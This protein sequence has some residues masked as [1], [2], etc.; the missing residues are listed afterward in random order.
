MSRVFVD[1]DPTALRGRNIGA[2]AL[3]S[4]L[5]SLERRLADV[6]SPQAALAVLHRAMLS[7]LQERSRLMAPERVR[8]AITRLGVLD[9]ELRRRSDVAD[10]VGLSPRSLRRD[11]ADWTGLSPAKLSRIFRFQAALALIRAEPDRSLTA[12]AFDAGYADHAHMVR[13]FRDL[14][15]ITP[16]AARVNSAG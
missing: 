9:P 10:A 1:A 4:R 14:G 13:E 12:I 8:S 15:T 11:I 16:S 5:T 2:P 3:D 6:T 7:A